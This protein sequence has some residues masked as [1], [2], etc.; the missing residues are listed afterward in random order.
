MDACCPTWI[1]FPSITTWRTWWKRWIGCTRMKTT[2]RNYWPSVL[3]SIVGNEWNS[4]FDRSRCN[5]TCIDCCWNT[6]PCLK[7]HHCNHKTWAA[8]R[9]GW[10]ESSKKL[11]AALRIKWHSFIEKN[12]IVC[13]RQ[14][15]RGTSKEVKWW[16]QWENYALCVAKTHRL[17][18]YWP[19]E[20]Q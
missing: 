8:M 14:A 13:I 2:N 4:S 18:V 15:L 17:L 6:K 10:T 3:F 19:I 16:R 1:T 5:A 12:V 20:L 9:G 7:S 11:Q